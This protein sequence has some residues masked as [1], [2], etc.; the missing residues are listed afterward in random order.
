MLRV[1]AKARWTAETAGS[2]GIIIP[3]R[4]VTDCLDISRMSTE[5]SINTISSR[6]SS[7]DMRTVI[8]AGLDTVTGRIQV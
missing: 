8:T 7:V 6:D 1:T 5:A 3:V 2:L 4:I